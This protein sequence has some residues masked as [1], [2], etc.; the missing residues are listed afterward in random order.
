MLTSTV[1]GVLLFILSSPTEAATVSPKA[2][3][4]KYI[5][6]S[7]AVG[8]AE[9]V[10]LT[11]KVRN[12]GHEQIT[13]RLGQDRKVGYL[14]VVTPP[15]KAPVTLSNVEQGGVHSIG[16]VDVASG[17]T[18]T[19][20]IL[21]NEWYDFSAQGKYGLEVRMLNPV[22]VGNTSVPIA[23]RGFKGSFAIGQRNAE[24]LR[25]TCE[26]LASEIGNT[27]G[28][29]EQWAQAAWELSHTVDPVS[30]PYLQ[31]AIEQQPMVVEILT[32]GLSRIA[33]DSAVEALLASVSSTN[34]RVRAA[35]WNSLLR[36]Q[37]R[38]ANPNL[39][40]TVKKRLSGEP[41]PL[42]PPYRQ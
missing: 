24:K 11:V 19:E 16:N 34:P 27:S 37:D 6:P 32:A 4:I 3:E 36:T 30:V 12:T 8:L 29:Y 26:R 22:L 31:Q 5:L 35:A 23:D 40:E 20:R 13:L 2:L 25:A 28:S 17:E 9:P 21:L 38:I 39:R 15:G 1:L 14:L 41:P 18:F 42:T 10:V 7:E 33:N